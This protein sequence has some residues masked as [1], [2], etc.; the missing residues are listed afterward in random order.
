MERVKTTCIIDDDP[1]YIYGTKRIIEELD[2]CDKLIEYHNGQD[3]IDG[4][5]QMVK[6]G[7]DIPSMIFLDLNMPVMNGWDFLEEFINIPYNNKEDVTI[8]I[9]SSSIDPRDLVKVKDYNIVHN[10]V[11]KP[12]SPD[13]LRTMIEQAVIKV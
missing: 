7:K 9:I 1:I 3:A 11:L 8:Y 2:F 6:E 5:A 13:E 10:Y 12:V 4:M